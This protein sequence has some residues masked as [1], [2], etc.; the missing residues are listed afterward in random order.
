M[1]NLTNHLKSGMLLAAM[2]ALVL[3]AAVLIGGTNALPFA[4]ILAAVMNV[5]A[6][7]FSHKLALASM[8]AQEVGPDHD[9]FRM[10]QE[11]APRAN[12]PMPKVYISP[13]AAP[14]AFATGRNPKHAV[15]CATAGLLKMLSREEVAAVMAHELAHVKHRDM[16]IQTIAATLGG[17]VSGLGYMFMFGGGDDEESPLGALGGLLVLILGPLA[18]GLMQMALSRRREFAADTEAAAIMGDPRPLASAL[19][20]IHHAAER[21]PMDTNPAFNALLIAEPRNLR[22]TMARLFSTH[23]PL[24]ERL[25][26][27]LGRDAA[28]PPRRGR[29]AAGY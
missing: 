3:A 24:E 23:P 14:N 12:L 2:T 29:V 21:I 11:L 8:R 28:L 15:V 18:A 7:F 17:A 27:L 4:I 25:E 1:R 22:K 19:Q 16:L 13:Y 26:N 9:L 10:V 5:G 20:K 6:Y